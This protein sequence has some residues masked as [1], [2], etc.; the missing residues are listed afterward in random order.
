MLTYQLMK[1][2]K[3]PNISSNKTSAKQYNTKCYIHYKLFYT[4][5]IRF[6]DKIY[7]PSK[8]TTMGSP[9][10]GFIVEIFLQYFENMTIKH[11]IQSNHITFYTHYVDNI[12][13]IYEHTHKSPPHR[14]YIMLRLFTPICNSNIYLILKPPSNFWIFSS[15]D[16]KYTFTGGN[17][18]LQITMIHFNYNHPIGHKL[19]IFHLLLKRMQQCPLSTSHKQKGMDHNS[20][21]CKSQ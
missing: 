5:I 13:I 14:S 2:Y 16:S 17:T 1:Q 8:G 18:H 6:D 9:I 21:H 11:I 12:L 15:I 10:S 7:K 3:S 4:K 19:A 20:T